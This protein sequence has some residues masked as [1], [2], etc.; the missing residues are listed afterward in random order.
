MF[1]GWSTNQ[2][3]HFRVVLCKRLQHKMLLHFACF[4]V[5]PLVFD[6][7]ERIWSNNAIAD[8]GNFVFT[9]LYRFTLGQE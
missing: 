2:P 4:F 9:H 8:I 3:P 6:F 7:I 1:G 5:D